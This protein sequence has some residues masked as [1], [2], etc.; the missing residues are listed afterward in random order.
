MLKKNE[1]SWI[2]KSSLII[3]VFF[4]IWWILLQFDN[5]V[6]LSLHKQIFSAF[7][8]LMALWGGIFGI[9]VS[10][11]WGGLKSVVG[12]AIIFLS[13]GLLAQEFGQIIYSF[14][15]F[16]FKI[17]SYPSI[18]DLGYF[19]SIFFYLIG[20]L[21]LGKASGVTFKFKTTKYKLLT[22]FIPL[23]LLG[24]SYWIFLKD[25]QFDLTNPLKIILDFGYPMG[26]TIYISAALLIYLFSKGILGGI[27]KS[28]ILFILFALLIQ[29]FADYSF[30][31][32][33]Y[34]GNMSPGGIND[35]IYLIAYYFM[36]ISL[37]ELLNAYSD[38]KKL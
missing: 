8:G 31:Y 29:F 25:Y 11:K 7:Y 2:I 27:M 28:K 18:G 16:F 37:I 20:L 4:T 34:Y 12:K 1:N 32:I 36:G 6:N 33:N 26:E 10:S 21:Y 23:L 38:I 13:L 9:Y 17:V 24:V 5:S 30:L 15:F 22:I 14:Y 19:G 35:F 3:F